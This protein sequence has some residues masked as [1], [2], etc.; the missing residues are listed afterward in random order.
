MPVKVYYEAYGCSQNIAETGM[1]AQSMGE[2]VENPEDA[3][4][5]LIGTCIVIGHTEHRM[6]R[7]I[8][9]MK[10][11]GKKVVVYGCL[12]SARYET[13]PP[14]VTAIRTWE[15]EKAHE[16]LRIPNSPMDEVYTM[17]RVATIPIANGCLGSCTYCITRLARGRIKSR[18]MGWIMKMVKKSI[19][20]GMKELRLSAQDTAA[21]GKDKGTN[22]ATLLREINSMDGDFRVRVGMMEP[23]ETMNILPELIEE[24]RKE[25]IYKFLHLPV[26]SGDD[27]ILRR[28]NRGYSVDDFIQIVREFRKKIPELMLSTDIIVGFPGESDESFENTKNLIKEIAPEILNITRFSPRPKTPAFRWKRPSTNDVKRW[29][30]ELADMHTEILKRKNEDMRGKSVK[31][32]IPQRGKRGNYIGRTDSYIP[33][34]LKDAILGSFARVKIDD[35]RNTYLLGEVIEYL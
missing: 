1:L 4:V 27:E 15:F 10:R 35:V 23:R 17:D 29:S 32:L 33:V 18:E 14:D 5:L 7:R 12:P 8:E 20:M 31:I 13:L 30:K 11:Y 25:K 24:Y 34:I 19:D 3:D 6:L 26:Q 28:M 22:L 21:W 9:E 16:I 2:I